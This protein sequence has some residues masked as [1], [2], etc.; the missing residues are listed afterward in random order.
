[1]ADVVDVIVK[2]TYEVENNQLR[3]AETQLN[4]NIS[5]AE[6]GQRRLDKLSD[7]FNKTATTETARRERLASLMGKQTA[8][9]GKLGQATVQEIQNNTRLQN[10]MLQQANTL[11]KTTQ[12]TN[13][14][15]NATFALS[16]VLREAPAFAFSF[17]TGL[18]AISN[19]LPVLAD[20]FKTLKAETGSTGTALATLGRSLF[21]ATNLLTIGVTLLTVFGG[22]M[23][24]AAN[25]TD[26][27]TDS[28]EE[29]R[30]K[31]ADIDKQSQTQAVNEITQLRILETTATNVAN[32][33][34]LR[35]AA[36][37]KLLELY[38]SLNAQTSQEAILN[39][40]AANAI[41]AVA[42]AL[43]KKSLA[44]AA[45]RKIEVISDRELDL[46]EQERTIIQDIQKARQIGLDAERIADKELRG[47]R[48]ATAIEQAGIARRALADNKAQRQELAD[49]R[50]E[51]L[52]FQQQQQS[53]AAAILGANA[54]IQTS[55]DTKTGKGIGKI[56]K[57]AKEA[58]FEVR[59]LE[60]SIKQI[61]KTLEESEAKQPTIRT[62]DDAFIQR[63]ISEI[64]GGASDTERFLFGNISDEKNP[65]LRRQKEIQASIDAYKL[66]SRT[67]ADTAN[68]IYQ[69]QIQQLDRE[70]QVRQQRVEAARVLA[71]RG[72]VEVL[73]LEEE[74]LRETERKR[75][76]FARKQQAVNAVLTLSNS[77]LAVATAA[78][79][80]GAGAIVIVPAVI[81]AIAAGFAA[82][83]QLTSQQGFAEGGYTGDGGKYEQ[84]G[85]VHKG[86][87][88]MT[89]ENTAKYRPILEAMHKGEFDV[90]NF[91]PAASTY[92]TTLEVKGVEKRL[93]KLTEA[94]YN[95]EV[96]AE[97]RFD[98]NGA[99]QLI[100]KHVR[101]D[102]LKWT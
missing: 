45:G 78:G 37:N 68:A 26:D 2:T 12:A 97:N 65:E 44:A 51:L 46:I 22:K 20:Q 49:Q 17:Q 6:N 83:T 31:I 56:A 84:A 4:K 43:I 59:L 64:S 11:Q 47:I 34:E 15:K 1:M 53:A 9:L 39:G 70:I 71:E 87:F 62:F 86:E 67:A 55:S 74:R 91:K 40:Q 30:K 36:A 102:R 101:R 61:L 60:R 10:V 72:N 81:A 24:E 29:F 32:S 48:Q 5:A 16:Q 66:L 7:A 14:A 50:N 21:S 35:V 25:K 41:N 99:T 3:E 13:T 33:Q 28:L 98:G 77:I 63:A 79:E 42:D 85:V 69:I 73:R 38:P 75:E 23:F 89:K 95:T 80:S 8:A 58:N 94:I 18:L 82:V 52:K 93:D 27:A 19:N 92:A 54:L 76:E 100:Q 57:D 90:Y 96:K 88:V